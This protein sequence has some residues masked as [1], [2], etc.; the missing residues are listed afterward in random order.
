[1]DIVGCQPVPRRQMHVIHDNCFEKVNYVLLGDQEWAVAWCVERA[2][3]GGMIAELVNPE[4]VVFA[5]LT[6]PVLEHECEMSYLPAA[7]NGWTRGPVYGR[8]GIPSGLPL[9]VLGDGY[10]SYCRHKSQ[11]WVWDPLLGLG[12]SVRAACHICPRT[13][14]KSGHR[15]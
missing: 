1:M 12:V 13:C 3:T 10:G 2:E 14:Q 11:Y 4:V 7:M 8:I 15:P 9:V 5:S 6:D